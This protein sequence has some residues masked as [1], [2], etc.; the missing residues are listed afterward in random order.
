M[1]NFIKSIFGS[2]KIVDTANDA[3]RKLGGLDDMNAKERAQFTLDY[4][5]ATKH[6]SPVRRAI[7][8][9][10]LI[11]FM[12][13]SGTWLL[14][15]LFMWVY[16]FFGGDAELAKNLDLLRD[17]VFNMLKEIILQP[18]NLVLSFYFV[19]HIVSNFGGK[20]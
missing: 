14:T 1:M 19:N 6:Q 11:G 20:K 9:C 16:L 13:F 8:T 10:M 5:A 17:D 2:S 7:A 4:I 12:L 15:T 3:I 18:F